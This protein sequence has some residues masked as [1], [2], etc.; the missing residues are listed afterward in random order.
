[1]ANYRAIKA[2]CEAV[3]ELLKRSWWTDMFTTDTLSFEVYNVDSFDSPTVTVGVTL[4]LYRVEVNQ[5]QRTL[6]A[7]PDVMGQSRRR[8]LPLDLHFVL[9]PWAETASEEQEILGWMMRAIEDNP[10]MPSSFLNANAEGVFAD[11]EVIEII[12]ELLSH[13][14][15]FRIWD[16]LTVDFHICVPYIA[17]VVRIDSD[18]NLAGGGPVL[19]RELDFGDVK[20]T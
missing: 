8:Q 12:P 9:I 20:N 3:I 17:R 15:I 1:M 14:E 6:P 18:L 11:G 2:T 10:V 7:P 19:T 16:S 13:E 4:F 5:T